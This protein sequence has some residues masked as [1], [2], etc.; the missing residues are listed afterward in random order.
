MDLRASLAPVRL[1]A[2]AA[3]LLLG[4]L[5][6]CGGDD[7]GAASSGQDSSTTSPPNDGGDDPTVVAQGI[8]YANDLTVA[9]GSA[10]RFDNQDSTVHTLTADDGAFD[11]GEVPG[12]NQSDPIAAPDTA[13]SYSFHCEIHS[14]MTGTLTVS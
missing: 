4:G 1:A 13:G 10:F 9:A 7:N 12:S 11:S 6:G 2:L 3:V 14:A 5:A 8:A